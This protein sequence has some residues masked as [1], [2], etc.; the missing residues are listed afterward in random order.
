MASPAFAWTARFVAEQFGVEE[1]LVE[2]IASMAMQPE[3]GRIFI[4]DSNDDNSPSVT[5]FTRDGIDYLRETL[6]DPS[7]CYYRLSPRP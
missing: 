2:E 6:G 7:S 5:A 4:I 1:D 3:D